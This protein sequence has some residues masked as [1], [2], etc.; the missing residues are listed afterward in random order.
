LEFSPS[1]FFCESFD[2]NKALIKKKIETASIISST[3]SIGAEMKKR[4]PAREMK[5]VNNSGCGTP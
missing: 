5:Y 4:G 2:S 1:K 3:S